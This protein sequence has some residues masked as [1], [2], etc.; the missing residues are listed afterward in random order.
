M[1]PIS[2]RGCACLALL[3]LAVPAMA[4]PSRIPATLPAVLDWTAAHHPALQRMTHELQARSALVDAAGFGPPLTL[5]AEVENPAGTG[6]FAGGDRLE[7]TLSLGGVLEW[8]GRPM[9]RRVEALSR[10]DVLRIELDQQRRDV[11]ADAALRFIDLAR[12]QADLDLLE[13]ALKAAEQTADAS[14]ERQQAGAAS[15][16][17]TQRATLELSAARLRIR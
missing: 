2:L 1:F 14:R 5:D 6:E 17:D 11:L 9:L 7:T 16:A 13:Q 8:G 15:A 10:T 12:A 4:Q 3:L